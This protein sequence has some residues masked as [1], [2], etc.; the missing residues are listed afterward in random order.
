MDSNII[1]NTIILKGVKKGGRYYNDYVFFPRNEDGYRDYRYYQPCYCTSRGWPG[2]DPR[3]VDIRRNREGSQSGSLMNSGRSEQAIMMWERLKGID[4]L[5]ELVILLSDE[6]LRIYRDG[7]LQEGYSEF[8][9]DEIGLRRHWYLNY[10]S[11]DFYFPDYKMVFELD[12]EYHKAGID[13]ARDRMLFL[14]YGIKTHRFFRFDK[15]KVKQEPEVVRALESP[16]LEVPYY[17]NQLDLLVERW[18]EQEGA[19][20]LNSVMDESPKCRG[21]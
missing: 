8:K 7:L 3:V 2:K 18:E 10:L 21:A 13:K 16:R 12:S 11:A 15:N 5:R 9:L 6:D 17:F 1:K 14:Q 19:Q 4:C 20:I